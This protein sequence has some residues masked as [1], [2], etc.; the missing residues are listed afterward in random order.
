MDKKSSVK[1]K[2]KTKYKTKTKNPPA[3]QVQKVEK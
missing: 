1:N 2:P 3:L